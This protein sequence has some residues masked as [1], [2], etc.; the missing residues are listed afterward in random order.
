MLSPHSLLFAMAYE[1]IFIK[2]NAISHSTNGLKSRVVFPH[3]MG[4]RT[5]EEMKF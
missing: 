1:I 2:S 3:L 5:S 4:L